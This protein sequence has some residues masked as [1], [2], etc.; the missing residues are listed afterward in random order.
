MKTNKYLYLYVVQGNY[1]S[2]YGWEDLTES[3]SRK[4]ARQ[5]LKDYRQN[6]VQYPHRMIKRR[7]LNPVYTQNC[8]NAILG[9]V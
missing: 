5:D 6:E 2:G 1:S 7:E 4:E 8:L 9:I 3:E